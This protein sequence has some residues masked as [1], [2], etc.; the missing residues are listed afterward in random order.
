M[1]TIWAK[2]F[3]EKCIPEI[4]KAISMEYPKKK[5]YLNTK[6]V[7]E[8]IL[9]DPK[10]FPILGKRPQ[11]AIKDLLSTYFGTIK[12]YPLYSKGRNTMNSGRIYVWL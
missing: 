4:D 5:R 9:S 2:D 3:I 1:N 8:Q 7:A 11:R 10:K 6:W 12:R